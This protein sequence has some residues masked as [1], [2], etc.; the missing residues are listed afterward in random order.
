LGAGSGV[1]PIAARHA[2][3]SL[4]AHGAGPAE[5]EHRRRLPD[6]VVGHLVAGGGLERA[7]FGQDAVQRRIESEVVGVLRQHRRPDEE[8]TDPERDHR[9]AAAGADAAVVL[10]NSRL[11]S[12]SSTDR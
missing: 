10:G 3:L 6:R 12:P 8:V 11:I 2:R 4:R 5:L 7:S 9:Q 1:E